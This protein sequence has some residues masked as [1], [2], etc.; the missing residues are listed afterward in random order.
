[1][2]GQVRK[3]IAQNLGVPFVEVED[4]KTLGD[5][6]ADDFDVVELLLDLEE[7]VGHDLSD[8]KV[9]LTSKVIDVIS[10]VVAEKK[11]ESND[12]KEDIGSGIGGPNK[13]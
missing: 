11:G 2:E 3:I 7:I 6:G 10:Y 4:E 12:S 5:L 9:T 1:M 8:E 13:E